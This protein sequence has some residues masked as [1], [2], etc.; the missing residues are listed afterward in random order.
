MDIY[1]L[2]FVQFNL[3]GY[4]RYCCDCIWNEICAISNLSQMS[5]LI[6]IC[7]ARIL[8]LKSL[9]ISQPLLNN[10]EVQILDSYHKF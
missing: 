7:I 9:H 10:L 4:T 8:R 1:I 2:Y 6:D 3:H 5:Q